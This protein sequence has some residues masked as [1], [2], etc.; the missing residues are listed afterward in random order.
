M[1][2]EHYPRTV[3]FCM[4]RMN[5]AISRLPHNT[6]ARKITAALMRRL[7]AFDDY[8]ELGEGFRDYINDIQLELASLHDCFANTWFSLDP[9]TT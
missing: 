5:Q 1:L 4:Q 8:D 6:E 9:G 7:D 2:N 3:M